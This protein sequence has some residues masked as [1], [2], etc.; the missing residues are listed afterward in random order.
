VDLVDGDLWEVDR[1]D[2]AE[3]F[4]L[5]GFE[6][7]EEYVHRLNGATFPRRKRNAYGSEAVQFAGASTTVKV[8]HKGPEF[9]VHDRRRLSAVLPQAKLGE[10]MALQA[11]AD[12]LLR[13]EVE[14]H[15]RKLRHDGKRL[16]ADLSRQYLESVHDVEAGRLLREGH[17]DMETV[18]RNREVAARL[19]QVYSQE[20]SSRLFGT[21]MQLAALGE[22][23]V[24]GK[25]NRAT[26][27]R[28]RKQLVDAGVGWTGADVRII[29]LVSLVPQGFAPV[30]RDPRRVSGECG[31]VVELLARYRQAAA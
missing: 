13:F 25:M 26:F 16:V 29:G 12:G 22:E 15:S 30:R 21:W 17:A 8:Y 20:L 31:Q 7:V 28:Q 23:V 2:W 3:C 5:P 6:A 1:V 24:R 19:E 4:L 9:R 14:V 18:R 10:L 27:Y 11:E